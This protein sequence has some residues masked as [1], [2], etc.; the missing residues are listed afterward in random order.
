MAVRCA[1]GA[2][3]CCYIG[4]VMQLDHS[5]LLYL[6]SLTISSS[7]KEL[8]AVFKDDTIAVWVKPE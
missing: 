2:D 5:C 7:S 4:Q 6:C 1:S 8:Y 3:V